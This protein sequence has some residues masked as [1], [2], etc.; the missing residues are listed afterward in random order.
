MADTGCG[1]ALKNMPHVFE[2]FFTTKD[3]GKGTVHGIVQQHN[4]W[5]TVTSE[6]N[7]GTRF[8][9]YF[10]AVAKTL[11][12]K[13]PE[14]ASLNLPRGTETIL[15]AEDEPMVRLTISAIQ[16]PAFKPHL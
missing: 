13:K 6:I 2:P 8:D 15:V 11:S 14:L 10:P 9:I 12:G 1:I 3:V 5:I 4:A 7:Q 16:L